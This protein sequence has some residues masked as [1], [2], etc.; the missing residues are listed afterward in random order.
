MERSKNFF[1]SSVLNAMLTVAY[2]SFVFYAFH[3]FEFFASAHQTALPLL[4]RITAQHVT[5]WQGLAV[6]SFLTN[7]IW[8]KR[9]IDHL[10]FLFLCILF[11]AV[12]MMFPFF[13]PVY[14]IR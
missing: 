6:V 7:I 4:S 12:G 10:I 14:V 3:F 11:H 8:R 5:L 9:E 2:C 1:I 13:M